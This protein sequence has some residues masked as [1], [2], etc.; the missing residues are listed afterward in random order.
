M[1]RRLWSAASVLALALVSTPAWTQVQAPPDDEPNIEDIVVTGMRVRQGGAQDIN[2]FRGRSES[3]Q[4][5]MP[6]TL[7][8]EGLMGGYDLQIPGEAC[9]RVLCVTGEAMRASL[10]LSPADKIL[11]G[12]GFNSSIDAATWKRQPLNLVAVVDK[13]GSMNGEPL[14]QVRASLRQILDQLRPGDQISIVLY[15]DRSYRHLEPTPV[16]NGK[17]AIRRAIDAIE[18]EGSTN[19]EEGLQV[20]YETAFASQP[21]FKGVT[22][23]MLFTD[24]QPNVGATDADSFMGMAREAS[25]RGIGLTTIGVGEQFDAPLATEISSVR[26]GNLFFL[27]DENDIKGVFTGKLD[28][29]VS[30]LAYDLDLSVKARPGYRIT[31]VYGVPEDGLK[32]GEDGAVS[33]SVP[34]AFLSTEGGGLMVGLAKAEGATYLPEPALNPG[35]SL[36]DVSLSYTDKGGASQTQALAVA[37]P[38]GAPS[39]GLR[40][41]HLL[42]DEFQSLHKV[43][44]L[45]HRDSDEEGAYQTLRRFDERLRGETDPKLAPERRLVANLLTRTAMLSGHAGE[46]PKVGPA[47]LVG[48]WTIARID[49]DGQIDL[50]RGDRLTFDDEELLVERRKGG[51]FEEDPSETYLVN[52]SQLSLEDSGL[53][54]DYRLADGDS[55]VLTHKALDLRLTL[56][57]DPRPVTTAAID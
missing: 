22:R 57:R 29:M 16:A 49:G 11:V 56:K 23:V 26:G 9:V 27:R 12:V 17:G 13:S 5:P 1:S 15:G 32:R 44:T 18:S 25:R 4:I 41:A 51:A 45:Y 33:I 20:G 52:D 46:V 7:T 3:G 34:T 14:D 39:S 2:H 38:S 42:I 10:P 31:G 30:E 40:L 55:L 8:P 6:D 50:K 19:M 47:G 24:E 37:A 54:F 21:G 36:L 35:D 48:A 43:A 53:V 28:T